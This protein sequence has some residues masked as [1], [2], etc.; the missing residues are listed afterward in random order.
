MNKLP[1]HRCVCDCGRMVVK[2]G[3][4]CMTCTKFN[5]SPE[6]IAANYERIR[7]R[8]QRAYDRATQA[9]EKSAK[10]SDEQQS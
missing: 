8:D 9:R 4:T 7:V 1:L 3:A 10:K 5:I 6:Q 2:E